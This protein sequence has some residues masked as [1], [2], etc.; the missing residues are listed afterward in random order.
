MIE[1]LGL[2]KQ[3]IDELINKRLL[4]QEAEGRGLVVTDDELLDRLKE[5]YG[6][7]DVTFEQY[8]R[9]VRRT[10]AQTVSAFEDEVRSDIVG[11]KVAKVLK[12]TITVSD[13]ELESI[14]VH[15]EHDRAMVWFVRFDTSTADSA[16]G[17]RGADRRAAGRRQKKR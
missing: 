15:A 7:T 4:A 13:S 16:T 5:Q 11:D 17:D 3:V 12:E 1:R 6:V 10:F 2:R 8:E 9:W 14:Y